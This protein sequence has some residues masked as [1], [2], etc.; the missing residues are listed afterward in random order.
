[1]DSA[2]DRWAN[3]EEFHDNSSSIHELKGAD[4]VGIEALVRCLVFPSEPLSEIEAAV[5]ETFVVP[6]YL[7]RFGDLLL[8]MFLP[9]EGA[10]VAHLGCRTG[11]LDREICQNVSKATVYGVESSVFALELAKNKVA[12]SHV[13]AQYI[14]GDMLPTQLPSEA[15]S[16]V[17]TLHP[18]VDAE[19][20]GALFAEMSRLLYAGGQALI[21]LPLRGSF[22]ELGDLFREYA[23]KNDDG[24]FG[25]IVEEAMANRPTVE[26]LSEELE[27][28]G[29]EDI[30]VE[31]RQ[32][33]LWFD[34][35]RAVL[36]DPITRLLIFPEFKHSLKIRELS[37]ALSYV[38]DAVDRYWSETRFELTV[39]VGCASARR[40]V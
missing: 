33:T 8:E 3:L 31:V 20:R 28:Y 7:H 16:H 11:Y 2:V 30:D 19:E 26:M 12:T 27:A 35:G 10:R 4:C 32:S 40:A 22:Q 5:F 14:S 9:T 23:L 13:Q 6:N 21:A 37:V 15:F 25:R 24:E 34:N 18:I 17:I 29:L 36:E 38:R 1:M 39:N